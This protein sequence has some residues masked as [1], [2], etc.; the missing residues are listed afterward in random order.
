MKSFKHEHTVAILYNLH[1]CLT[2]ACLYENRVLTCHGG[3]TSNN[4]FL[5]QP[6]AICMTKQLIAW[7]VYLQA[8]HN[9]HYGIA[10]RSGR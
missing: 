4:M 6:G 10:L 8:S 7:Y 2:D 1:I 9:S 5:H 3:M